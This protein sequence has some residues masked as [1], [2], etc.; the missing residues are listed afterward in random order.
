MSF[1]MPKNSLSI[2]YPSSNPLVFITSNFSKSQH[3]SH[4]IHI[5]A[6]NSR[7]TAYGQIPPIYL[8]ICMIH[9]P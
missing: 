8:L 5:C 6:R 3:D 7:Q 9:E 1:D 4:M 2:Y